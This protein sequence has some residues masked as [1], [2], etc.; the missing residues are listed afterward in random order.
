M[1]DAAE[2]EHPGVKGAEDRDP[3]FKDPS[4]LEQ[5]DGGPAMGASGAVPSGNAFNH[6]HTANPSADATKPETMPNTKS[7]PEPGETED[8]K[9]V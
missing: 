4:T 7:T 8:R 2:D 1:P 9:P 3:A 5:P 6:W